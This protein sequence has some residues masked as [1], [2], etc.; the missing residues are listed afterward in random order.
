MTGRSHSL[1]TSRGREVE[2]THNVVLTRRQ[3]LLTTLVLRYSVSLWRWRSAGV[4]TGAGCA[5]CPSGSLVISRRCGVTLTQCRATHTTTVSAHDHSAAIHR[6]SAAM[7]QRRCVHR[8]GWCDCLMSLGLPCDFSQV[9]SHTHTMS[10]N[11][12]TPVSAHDRS[13]AIQRVTAAI[14][15]RR[16]VHRCG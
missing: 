11:A 4:C 12:A 10:C 2:H 3:C 7:T 15:Q 14:A 1:L 6:V 5:T 16:C 9:W 8:R 13:A